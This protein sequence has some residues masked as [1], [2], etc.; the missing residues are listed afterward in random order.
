MN[1]GLNLNASYLAF[2]DSGSIENFFD[3]CFDSQFT[4]SECRDKARILETYVRTYLATRINYGNEDGSRICQNS[5]EV[6]GID[7]LFRPRSC[8]ITH[9]YYYALSAK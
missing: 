9:A 1:I 4:D 6:Y 7:P 8:N 5:T 2:G 3:S